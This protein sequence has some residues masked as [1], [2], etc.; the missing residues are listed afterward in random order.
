MKIKSINLYLAKSF[1]IKFAQITLGFS[2]LIFLINFIDS[3][4]KVKAS[5]GPTYIAAL[6]AF[7]QI[8][9]FYQ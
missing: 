3:L 4:E 5:E 9:D 7:L 1:L 8:P 2:M 6:M